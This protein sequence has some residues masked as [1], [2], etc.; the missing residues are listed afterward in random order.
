MAFRRSGAAPR[1]DAGRL[2]DK[3]ATYVNDVTRMIAR[4][5]IRDSHIIAMAETEVWFDSA[6]STTGKRRGLRSAPRTTD[7]DKSHVTVVL[8]ANAEGSKLKPYVVFRSVRDAKALRGVDGAV[9]S[10]NHHGRMNDRLTVDWLRKVLGKP[11]VAPRLLVWDSGGGHTSAAVAEEL[12]QG[13]DVATAV[14]PEGCAEWIHAPDVAWIRPFVAGLQQCYDGWMAGDA[15]KER[16][17]GG[18]VKAPAPCLL[19]DWVLKVWDEL[20]SDLLKTSFKVCGLTVAPDGSEDHLIQCFKE[21]EPW[22]SGRELLAQARQQGLESSG[23]EEEEEEEHATVKKEELMS[24]KEEEEEELVSVKE[25]EEE[26]VCVKEEE[27][28]DELVCVKLENF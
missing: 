3:L 8:A 13:Y 14:V 19:V 18:H 2:A 25:E 4:K 11:G 23:V 12:R 10:A 27:E 17:A 26:L 16:T 15:G 24:V 6:I 20:D 22:A 21:G 1:G 7:H 5:E 9:V 28:E